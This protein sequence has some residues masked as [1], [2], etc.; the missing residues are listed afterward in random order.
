MTHTTNTGC[1]HCGC[2]GCGATASGTEPSSIDSVSLKEVYVQLSLSETPLLSVALALKIFPMRTDVDEP[3][4]L[5]AS[6][7]GV[8]CMSHGMI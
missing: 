5:S 8:R 3:A 4:S 2:C 7:I 6:M 1:M